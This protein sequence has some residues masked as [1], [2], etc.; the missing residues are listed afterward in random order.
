MGIGRLRSIYGEVHVTFN[1]IYAALNLRLVMRAMF[2]AKLSF[3]QGIL[4][5]LSSCDWMPCTRSLFF[6]LEWRRR[7]MPKRWLV[8]SHS[9]PFSLHLCLPL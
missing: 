2:C 5:S 6:C 3:H 8:A 4:F 7:E 1:S 9:L